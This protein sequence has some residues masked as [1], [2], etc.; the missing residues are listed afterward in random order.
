MTAFLNI[1]DAVGDTA[2][3]YVKLFEAPVEK[4]PAREPLCAR[5]SSVRLSENSGGVDEYC[6]GWG[7]EWHTGGFHKVRRDP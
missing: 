2:G 6:P 7:K 1:G 4:K 5:C 3:E